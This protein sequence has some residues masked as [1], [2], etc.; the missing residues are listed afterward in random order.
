MLWVNLYLY[1]N[2]SFYFGLDW[3]I[4]LACFPFWGRV[5]PGSGCQVRIWCQ[6][7]WWSKSAAGDLRDLTTEK[8]HLYVT[9]D[10]FCLFFYSTTE[11]KMFLVWILVVSEFSSWLSLSRKPFHGFLWLEV[12]VRLSLGCSDELKTF[13]PI[14]PPMILLRMGQVCIMNEWRNGFCVLHV[15]G[16]EWRSSAEKDNDDLSFVP[17]SPAGFSPVF[18]PSLWNMNHEMNPR[19][20]G[21]R[22]A[23]RWAQKTQQLCRWC[24]RDEVS[25]AAGTCNRRQCICFTHH[26]V[27]Q[28]QGPAVHW[29]KTIEKKWM[30]LKSKFQWPLTLGRDCHLEIKKRKHLN[31]SHWDLDLSP[32]DCLTLIGKLLGGKNAD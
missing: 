19:L 6:I 29:N 23:T 13:S 16:A 22:R 12:S 3:K 28:Q 9:N 31:S 10:H 11:A 25:A 21:H 20:S 30:R 7:S 27:L 5:Q 1:R 2:I 17:R 8:P 18:R 24:S 14:P 4:L 32:P 26:S 15:S